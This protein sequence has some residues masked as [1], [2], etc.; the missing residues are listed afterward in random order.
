AQQLA[1]GNPRLL[2]WLDKLLLSHQDLPTDN[3][4]TVIAT[5]G[6]NPKHLTSGNECISLTKVDVAAILNKLEVDSVELREQVLAKELLQQMDNTMREMLQ[7]G[8]VFELPV[9]REALAAVC[10]TIAEVQQYIDKAIALGLL[11][12]SP[13]ES[14]RVPRI[15]PLE[16]LNSGLPTDNKITVIATTG[17]NREIFEIAAKVLYR[18]WWKERVT[19]EQILE[20]HR[21]ALLARE[22]EIAAVITSDL[23]D[24]WINTSR[25][26]EAVKLCKSTL[27][28]TQDYRVLHSLARS[29]A[30]LGDVELAEQHYQQALEL[31]PQE[32]EKEKATII[33]NFAIIYASRGDVDDAIDRALS[34]VF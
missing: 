23:G 12:V 2:E 7:L 9:P 4:T 10:E 16:K 11:E 27:D 19:E 28:I 20:I 8:L 3:V 6:S 21:L 32:D 1:D 15:L 24:S 17:S 25:F 14:L 31:C 5:Q 29:E 34:T 30:E 33:H 13:D 18:L 26:R 22:I